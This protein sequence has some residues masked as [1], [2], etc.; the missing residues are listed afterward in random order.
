MTSA[1]YAWID[2]AAKGL[3]LIAD[4]ASNH[5]PD[6]IDLGIDPALFNQHI[7]I[8]LGV[9]PL[10]R[11]LAERLGA[12]AILGGVSR[13][14][15]DYNREEEAR[16][17]I[18]HESDGRPIPGNQGLSAAE[19]DRRIDEYFRA[20]H[21]RIAGWI[22]EQQ[23]QLLVSVHSFTPELATRPEEVRPWPI[24]ILYNEDERAARIA[25]DWLRAKGINAGDNEPYSGRVLNATMN[26]HGE[27]NNIPYVGIEVRQDRLADAAGVSHWE[28]VIEAM[29]GEVSARIA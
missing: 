16:G 23:P 27:T 29:I 12:P 22:A 24:G 20:Y 17:L 7:A 9:E 6:G 1:G 13:L 15:I 4:H 8:D 26:R 19:R 5:V 18:P 2:G 21:D 25:I 10:T 11:A 14:V 3:L 28:A